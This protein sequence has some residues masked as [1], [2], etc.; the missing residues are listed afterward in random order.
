M[1]E[2]FH[3]G[4]W[5]WDPEAALPELTTFLELFNPEQP[6]LDRFNP[7]TLRHARYRIRD[8]ANRIDA[9]DLVTAV[10]D[11]APPPP[12]S[13]PPPLPPTP[14]PGSPSNPPP[15]LPD[16]SARFSPMTT[17]VEAGVENDPAVSRFSS[18]FFL[19]AD[20]LFVV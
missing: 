3:P 16:S 8:Y 19:V 18:V 6:G 15:V 7:S 13:A 12:S 1:M 17:G 14:N 9:L 20:V 11:P 2:R 10:V 5:D 4:D